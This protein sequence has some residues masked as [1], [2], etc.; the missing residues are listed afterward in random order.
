MT[1]ILES[2]TPREAAKGSCDGRHQA[3][4]KR[5]AISW[6]DATFD[7][8]ASAAKRANVS[9]AEQVRRLVNSGLKSAV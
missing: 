4:T 9:F 7:R 6:D 3:E 5:V 2:R 8:V 1:E